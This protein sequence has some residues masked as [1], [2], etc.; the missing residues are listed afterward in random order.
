MFM[1]PKSKHDSLVTPGRFQFC[2]TAKIPWFWVTSCLY[3]VPTHNSPHVHIAIAI[4]VHC[5]TSPPRSPRRRSI[6]ILSSIKNHQQSTIEFRDSIPFHFHSCHSSPFYFSSLL[7][8]FFPSS[9]LPFFASSLLP[10]SLVIY[11]SPHAMILP[12]PL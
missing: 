1:R 8:L 11:A 5:R 10:F 4:A 2:N 12:C 6:R 3:R 7:L 9:L